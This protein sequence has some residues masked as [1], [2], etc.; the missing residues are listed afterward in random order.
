MRIWAPRCLGGDD[1]RAAVLLTGAP[2]TCLAWDARADKVMCAAHA[3]PPPGPFILPMMP[4]METAILLA[5][6]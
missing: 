6:S 4:A 1:A 2:V 5:S 3:A